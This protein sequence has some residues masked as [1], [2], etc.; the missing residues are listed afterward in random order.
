MEGNQGTT[1]HYT[2]DEVE[3]LAHHSS[4]AIGLDMD[5]SDITLD[6]ILMDRTMVLCKMQRIDALT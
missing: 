6:G 2:N 5:G 1:Q 4:A 3:A